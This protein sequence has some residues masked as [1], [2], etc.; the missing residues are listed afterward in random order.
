[1][2]SKAAKQARTTRLTVWLLGLFP[3]ALLGWR[4]YREGLGTNPIEMLIEFTGHWGLILLLCTLAV[5]PLRRWTG[6][7]A[8]VKARRPLGLFAFFYATLHMLIYLGLDQTFDW[9]YVAEDVAKRRYITVGAAAFTIL[10]S[11]AATSTKGWIRRLGKRWVKLHR[12]VYLAAPLV[13]VHYWWQVK[14]DTRW[15]WVAALVFGLLMAARL[16][17]RGSRDSASRSRMPEAASRAASVASRAA[18]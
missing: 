4:L 16:Y 6:V 2:S 8:L 18:S 13:V 10:L 12:G 7:N 11:L 14:A 5:T 15:P 9:E 17:S 3:L 1:M